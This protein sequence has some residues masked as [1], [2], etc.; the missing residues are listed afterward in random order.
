MNKKGV[1]L[2]VVLI[3]IVVLAILSAVIALRSASEKAIGQRYADSLRAFWLAE[4]GVNQELWEIKNHNGVPQEIGLTALGQGEY[5]VEV[6]S[7]SL[8][9]AYGYVPSQAFAQA[10]RS[11]DLSLPFYD[12]VLYVA[13]DL[14]IT[15]NDY[16]ITGDVVYGGTGPSGDPPPD[17]IQGTVTQDA[18]ISPL[19]ILDFDQLRSISQSQGNYH[20]AGSLEGPFPG[21]YWYDEANKVPNVVFLEGTLTLKGND[22]VHG[23]FVVGGETIYDTTLAGNVSVDGCI[24]TRGNFTVRGG[25]N[26]MNIQGSVWVGGNADLNGSVTL[27][28]QEDYVRAIQGLNINRTPAVIWKDAENP[29]KLN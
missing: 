29:F 27:T 16:S 19:A 6:V 28:F 2:I 4:A 23:F 18:S 5:R 7:P 11:I 21:S 25:G 17:N 13:Q 15:G 24:Y 1:G 8:L 9:R 22:N 10:Q 26:A 14:N 12:S 3:V 20:D